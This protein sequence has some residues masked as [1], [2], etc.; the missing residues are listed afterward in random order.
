MVSS[1]NAINNTVGASITGVTNTLTVTNP[2]NTASS[3]ARTKIT[4]GGS[5]AGD[6]SLNF[7]VSG[8]T[9][10]EMGIDNSSSDR[11]TISASNALGTT[12]TWRMTTAGE[13][14]MPL[15]PA[16][17]AHVPSDLT[18]VSG[19]GTVYTVALSTEDFD[20]NGDYD[21]ATYT[22]TAPVTGK[23]LFTAFIR[24]QNQDSAGVTNTRARIVTSNLNYYF[25]ATSD[26]TFMNNDQTAG[27]SM[28]AEL[29]A[30]DTAYMDYT[31]LNGTKTCAV[32]GNK[33]GLG[34]NAQNTYFT[35]FL[36]C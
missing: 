35:G 12:D 22:F 31:A 23:Y 7:N 25:Y 9:D 21:N 11:L 3:A 19:D 24:V 2:S 15:Q 5:S 27:G 17:A 6:P 29:D 16:F 34:V 1:N 26:A 18:N 4:V 32:V 10:F 36:C 13:R 30:G 20:Q 28:L 14:T 33:T 8:V